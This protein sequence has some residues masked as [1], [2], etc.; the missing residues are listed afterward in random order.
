VQV[1]GITSPNI[2]A[3][4]IS[5]LIHLFG[6]VKGSNEL[7]PH[8]R[9]ARRPNCQYFTFLKL[10]QEDTVVVDQNEERGRE[11]GGLVV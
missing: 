8:T 7:Y 9:K 2:Q 10:S 11:C 1:P 3:G 6:S 4:S 5:G